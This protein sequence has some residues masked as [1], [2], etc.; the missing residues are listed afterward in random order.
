[1]CVCDVC[2]WLQTIVKSENCFFTELFIINVF[3]ECY[4]TK[5]LFQS[6]IPRRPPGGLASLLQLCAA[7]SS[8]RR[9]SDKDD[10]WRSVEG[11][12]A[13]KPTKKNPPLFF[14]FFS[15]SINFTLFFF[16]CHRRKQ[17]SSTSCLAGC[18]ARSCFAQSASTRKS[19]S[20]R[21][22]SC[23]LR[24]Q[25]TLT[26]WQKCWKVIRGLFCVFSDKCCVLTFIR[27]QTHFSFF[28][29]FC[30][31]SSF[32]HNKHTNIHTHTHTHTHSHTHTHT[33]KHTHIQLSLVRRDWKRAMNTDAPTVLSLW[34]EWEEEK[35]ER[36]KWIDR[37]GKI[38][39]KLSSLFVPKM[40]SLKRIQTEFKSSWPCTLH[41]TSC[42]C[43]LSVSASGSLARWIILFYFSFF[44]SI[45]LCSLVK[46]LNFFFFFFFR[47][48]TR[49][50]SFPEQFNLQVRTLRFIFTYLQCYKTHKN[51]HFHC[52][53]SA[54]YD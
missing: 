9:C 41:Q 1:M 36:K 49:Q 14:F 24:S 6:G 15:S 54:L 16:L 53:F 21:C 40:K 29:Y 7:C 43:N 28:L 30:I 2:M 27:T 37:E 17:T 12:W 13:T 52:T 4:F 47:Q 45:F 51:A 50:I 25:N 19:D 48:V 42:A 23:R 34:G 26:H 35:K 20:S 10:S 44:F 32:F 5:H 39:N 22:W 11:R 33:H 18:H 46:L 31:F 8:Q 3:R 38:L